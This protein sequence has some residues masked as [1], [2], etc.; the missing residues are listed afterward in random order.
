M[1][2]VSGCVGNCLCTTLGEDDLKEVESDCQ[3]V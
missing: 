2:R 1:K 3:T